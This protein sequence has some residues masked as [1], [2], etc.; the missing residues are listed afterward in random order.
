[1]FLHPRHM[2]VTEYRRAARLQAERLLR[3]FDHAF[4]GLVREA[5]DQIEVDRVDP[6]RAQTRARSPRSA[7]GFDAG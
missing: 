7:R 6:D 1:M 4:G 3:R 5:I 2:R